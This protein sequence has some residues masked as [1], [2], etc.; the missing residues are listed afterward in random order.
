[1]SSRILGDLS[2]CS[3]VDTQ[4]VVE[5]STPRLLAPGS[6]PG[7]ATWL[8]FVVSTNLMLA[9]VRWR[10]QL[11]SHISWGVGTDY[12]RS[13]G[14]NPLPVTSLASYPTP[15]HTLTLG[16]CR[17]SL[18]VLCLQHVALGH[19]LITQEKKKQESI[20]AGCELLLKT[21][22]TKSKAKKMQ[23]TCFFCAKVTSITS[24]AC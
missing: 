20:L 12:R 24:K 11:G 4:R 1:M 22:Y 16:P 19:W 9:G 10:T 15:F 13:A 14:G 23:N 6:N 8:C 21:I 3:V 17:F 18:Y 2:Q 7:L 5:W